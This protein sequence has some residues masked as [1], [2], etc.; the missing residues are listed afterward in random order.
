[1][2]KNVVPLASLLSILCFAAGFV[3]IALTRGQ[4]IGPAIPLFLIAFLLPSSLKMANQWERAVLLRLGKY[5]GLRG[6]GLF[7]IIPFID[8]VPFYID[9]RIQTTEITAEAALT[10]D[11]VA[12]N[13][14]A[15]V[16]WQVHDAEKA[17]LEIA[18]YRQAIERVAQ[19]SLREMIGSNDLTT[20]LSDR[21]TADIELQR[22]I[23]TKTAEWGIDV[24]S[25]E[26][27]DIAIPAGLQDAMSR[28]AQAEREKQARVTLASA[29]IAV[30]EQMVQAA[31][32]YE[33]HPAAMRLRQMNLLYEMNKDRGTTILIPTEMASSLSGGIAGAIAVK[34]L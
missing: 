5:Q 2:Y 33:A 15:I 24:T 29:E 28:Q 4:M 27:K 26:I 1:M 3:L 17:A 10:K 18:N 9:N 12:V 34:D 22:V 21:K 6:P 20:L 31:D 7:F 8:T 14:D 11:T 23:G 30:A 13:M 19:T 25:V 16:F 32:L